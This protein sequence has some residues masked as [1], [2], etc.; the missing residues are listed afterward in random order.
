MTLKMY[1]YERVE[2]DW[3]GA[4]ELM[5]AV[6]GLL[7]HMLEGREDIIGIGVSTPGPWM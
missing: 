4:E 7:D 1:K 6:S 2:H 3:S 5:S